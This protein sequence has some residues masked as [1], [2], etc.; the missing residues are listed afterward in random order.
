MKKIHRSNLA[1]ILG[2]GTT[3]LMSVT[4]IDFDNM[5]WHSINAW[6][7][8]LIICLPAIG[9]VTSE[10]KGNDDEPKTT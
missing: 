8:L 10:I 6:R 1:T 9:G 3:L 4:V 7:D 2:I 5:N